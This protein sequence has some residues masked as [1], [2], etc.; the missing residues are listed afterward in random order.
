MHYLVNELRPVQARETLKAMMGVGED[1]GSEERLERE[2]SVCGRARI[3]YTSIRARGPTSPRRPT[4][5]GSCRTGA[6]PSLVKPGPS[7]KPPPPYT[8]WAGA[9]NRLVSN[10]GGGGGWASCSC[11]GGGAAGGAPSEAGD[12]L[13]VLTAPT[14]TVQTRRMRAL[15]STSS[16]HLRRVSSALSSLHRIVGHQHATRPQLTDS[17]TAI[18]RP[19]DVH[20]YSG[21]RSPEVHA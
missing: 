4:S 3:S 6:T 9:G 12:G 15:K 10:S 14:G 18:Q 21:G 17:Q 8:R 19:N 1:E 2:F 13:R 7:R 5:T 20:G 11:G 16:P